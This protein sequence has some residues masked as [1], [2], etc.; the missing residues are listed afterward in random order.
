MMSKL[1]LY[2]AQLTIAS[3]RIIGC[4]SA[5][6]RLRRIFEISDISPEEDGT[7]MKK[8]LS[9]GGETGETCRAFDEVV[10]QVD[11]VTEPWQRRLQ[12]GKDVDDKG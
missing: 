12:L 7:L 8:F 4:I 6:P 2:Q 5:R 1:R 9:K 3:Y 11:Q 10:L